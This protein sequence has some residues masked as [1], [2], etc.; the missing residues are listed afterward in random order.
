MNWIPSRPNFSAMRAR[1]SFM[2]WQAEARPISLAQLGSR[3]INVLSTTRAD[4]A[5]A[6][7]YRS[8]AKTSPVKRLSG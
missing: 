6:R 5:M 8:A 1:S 3:S 2:S 4:R 7:T